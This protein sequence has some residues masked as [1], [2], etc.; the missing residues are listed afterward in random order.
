MATALDNKL[1]HKLFVWKLGKIL[2]D[3]GF[4]SIQDDGSLVTPEDQKAGILNFDGTILTMDGSTQKRDGH[5]TV[6]LYDGSLPEFL[7]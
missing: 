6:T 1:E 2:L 7:G 3:F 4:A 5:P